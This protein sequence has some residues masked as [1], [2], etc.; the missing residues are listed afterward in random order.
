[1]YN[2]RT[3]S[4][5]LLPSAF[6]HNRPLST[7]L[8]SLSLTESERQIKRAVAP[9]MSPHPPSKSWFSAVIWTE[10]VPP[11]I[12]KCCFPPSIHPDMKSCWS[13]QDW[14][15]ELLNSLA[16]VVCVCVVHYIENSNFKRSGPRWTRIYFAWW[17]LAA[18]RN[19]HRS[20]L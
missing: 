5:F 1:M 13:W 17:D 9:L 6:W 4:F 2:R 7:S 10:T 14:K 3:E 19:I 16:A 15:V 12:S 18:P 11:P 20:L 8:A